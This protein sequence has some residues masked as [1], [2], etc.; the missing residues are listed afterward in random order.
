VDQIPVIVHPVPKEIIEIIETEEDT[1]VLPTLNVITV[2]NV[3][4]HVHLVIRVI[5]VI[6]IG[7]GIESMREGG[8]VNVLLLNNTVID[9]VEEGENT[10]ILI[11][12][13]QD[14][15][16]EVEGGETIMEEEEGEGMRIEV[17]LE[18]TGEMIDD[19]EVG[20]EEE[21]VEVIEEEVGEEE[22][23]EEGEEGMDLLSKDS[24]IKAIGGIG[25]LH[26]KILSSLV[27]AR[28]LSLHGM[29][30][31]MGLRVSLLNKLN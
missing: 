6:G 31:L 25:V 24:Q 19:K 12:G 15:G 28:D 10:T 7:T 30:N 17:H 29:S 5:G 1:T 21:E 18:D 3:E 8:I 20:I 13:I 26:P 11:V 14:I 27:N 23:G 22:E 2:L 16:V 9:L 4:D